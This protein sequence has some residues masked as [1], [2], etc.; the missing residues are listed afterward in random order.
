MSTAKRAVA[1]QPHRHQRLP[2]R[3][4]QRDERREQRE[5]DD[6]ARPTSPTLSQPH[7]DGLLQPEHGDPHAGAHEQPRR[8]RRSARG[9]GCW[10]G[11]ERSSATI[12]MIAT[13]TLIQ[14]IERH[15]HWVR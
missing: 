14:K 5:A 6:E 3:S 11:F 1:E 2:T 10:S 12:A 15:V 8:A 7:D 4:S 13:G 9:C